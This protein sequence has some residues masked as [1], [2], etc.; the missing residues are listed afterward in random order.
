[1]NLLW[2]FLLLALIPVELPGLLASAGIAASGETRSWQEVMQEVEKKSQVVPQEVSASDAASLLTT[3]SSSQ[4][5]FTTNK[6]S[7][8]T[9]SRFISTRPATGGWAV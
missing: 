8:A 1:M 4:K 6:K 3:S 5:A 7:P 9:A 2:F